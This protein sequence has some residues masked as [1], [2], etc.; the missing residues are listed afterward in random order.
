MLRSTATAC[1][2]DDPGSITDS[3]RFVS[4]PQYPDR[5]CGVHPAFCPMGTGAASPGVKRKGREADHSPR[6]IVEIKNGGVVPPLHLCLHG[7]V[8]N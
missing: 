6:T 8:L 4:S 7:M 3:A 5:L 1:G 2:L